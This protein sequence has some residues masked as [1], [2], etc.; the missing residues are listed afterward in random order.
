[1]AQRLEL[2]DDAVDGIFLKRGA[3]PSAPAMRE[4]YRVAKP[5]A[6][7]ILRQPA[8]NRPPAAPADYGDWDIVRREFVPGTAPEMIV[9]LR[10]VKPPRP[11]LIVAPPAGHLPTQVDLRS[12]FP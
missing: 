8:C 2:P 12:T 1:M 5:G 6:K 11:R 7:F 10:A 9:E 3:P 4:L